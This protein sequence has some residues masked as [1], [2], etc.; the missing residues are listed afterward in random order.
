MSFIKNVIFRLK[1]YFLFFDS[2][3]ILADHSSPAFSGEWLHF[4]N[5][6]VNYIKPEIENCKCHHFVNVSLTLKFSMAWHFKV[7]KVNANLN[8]AVTNFLNPKVLSV[9]LVPAVRVKI[10]ALFAPM[11]EAQVLRL[12]LQRKITII[13]FLAFY[14]LIFV[15][16]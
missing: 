13:C 5:D 4:K 8:S 7:G 12:N 3:L 10:V 2:A 15:T 11:P 14:L 6:V 16:Y 9:M 1:T